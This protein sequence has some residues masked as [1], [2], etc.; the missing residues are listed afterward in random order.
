MN[1]QNQQN[2]IFNQF[3]IFKQNPIQFLSQRGMNV[4]PQY[5]NN[6]KGL[7]QNMLNSGQMSQEQYNQLMQTAKNMGLKLD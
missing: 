2:Q 4:P 6:P 5:Q 7:V 1:Q 3:N